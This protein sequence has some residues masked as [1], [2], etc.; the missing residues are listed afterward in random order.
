MTLL[1]KCLLK[2]NNNKI[3]IKQKR[4]STSTGNQGGSR[5]VKTQAPVKKNSFNNP[6]LK[7]YHT[8]LINTLD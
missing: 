6:C 1:L 7:N 8:L 5:N 2:N 3:E 4:S